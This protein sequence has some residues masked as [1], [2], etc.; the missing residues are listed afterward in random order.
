ML[1][2]VLASYLSSIQYISNPSTKTSRN[3]KRKQV[4]TEVLLF[5]TFCSLQPERRG[6]LQGIKAPFT[7]CTVPSV[8]LFLEPHL[9]QRPCWPIT[10]L[11]M[12]GAVGRG[13][14]SSNKGCYQQ[15]H[16]FVSLH[17]L[18]ETYFFDVDKLADIHVIIS[19]LDIRPYSLNYLAD[20]RYND[21]PPGQRQGL[22]VQKLLKQGHHVIVI[23]RPIKKAKQIHFS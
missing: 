16:P 4:I 10:P 11:N 22:V 6:Q 5:A 18:F 14:F 12:L 17:P 9:I 15:L 3:Q 20:H 2:R 8:Q 23:S 21:I 1:H 13:L 7:G 19:V